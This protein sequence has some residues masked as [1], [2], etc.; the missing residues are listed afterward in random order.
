M[1]SAAGPFGW[2]R[3]NISLVV[4]LGVVA[5]AVLASVTA[6]LFVWPSAPSPTSADAVAIFAGGRGE[7]LARAERLMADGL[8]SNLVIPNGT[9]P[10]W[11][12]GNSACREDR[13]YEV[14]CPAPTPDTTQGEARAIAGLARTRGWNRVIVVTSSYQVT[15]ADLLLGRCFDGDIQRVSAHPG[16]SALAWATRVGH[17]LLAWTHA[18]TIERGC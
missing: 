14:F 16:L 7:R 2:L 3:R 10:E 5:L 4:A 15:R 1:R 12:A 11:P 8:A 17:E 18:M 6:R 13:P 9:A